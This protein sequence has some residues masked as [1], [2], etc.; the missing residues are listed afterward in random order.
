MEQANNLEFPKVD[1]HSSHHPQDVG[2]RGEGTVPLLMSS[3]STVHFSPDL[4]VAM[5]ARAVELA[6]SR[7]RWKLKASARCRSPLRTAGS[8]TSR[9]TN[10]I[11]LV[12]SHTH[13]LPLCPS[14]LFFKRPAWLSEG[15]APPQ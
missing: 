1:R 2:P 13:C 12:C 8:G 4:R 3:G 5:T 10:A 7:S 11:A 14:Q 15:L 9:V 6:T